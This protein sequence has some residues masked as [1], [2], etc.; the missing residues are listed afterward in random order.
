[1]GPCPFCTGLAHTHTHARARS[2]PV[3]SHRWWTHT[4]VPIH[5]HAQAPEPPA[6]RPTRVTHHMEACIT[7]KRL[8]KCAH[9]CCSLGHHETG[10]LP[11]RPQPLLYEKHHLLPNPRCTTKQRGVRHCCN[12]GHHKVCT[13]V[14]VSRKRNS[15]QL[16]QPPHKHT[17]LSQSAPHNQSKV[18]M[19]SLHHPLTP[20]APKRRKLKEQLPLSPQPHTG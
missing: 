14:L 2:R 18:S 15:P 9:T 12:R 5:Y 20:P 4:T 19:R 10:Y 3:P 17:C 13:R 11:R 1:M 8:C 6:L 7:C 16:A